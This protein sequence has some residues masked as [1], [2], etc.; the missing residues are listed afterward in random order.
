MLEQRDA[1]KSLGVQEHRWRLGK[2]CSKYPR[3]CCRCWSRC[4]GVTV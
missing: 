4:K 3:R 2:I 1:A